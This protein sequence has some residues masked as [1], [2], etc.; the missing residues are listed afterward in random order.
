MEDDI[1]VAKMGLGGGQLRGGHCKVLS[2][3][4]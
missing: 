4:E 1:R 2:F 3:M